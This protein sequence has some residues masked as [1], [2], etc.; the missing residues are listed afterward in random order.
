MIVTL[1]KVFDKA[2]DV[3]DQIWLKIKDHGWAW[4]QVNILAPNMVDWQVFRYVERSIKK[5]ND[6]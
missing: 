3:R 5:L 4:R 2:L 1:D 6:R